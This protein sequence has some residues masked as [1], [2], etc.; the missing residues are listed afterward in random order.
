MNNHVTSVNFTQSASDSMAT[1]CTL[2]VGWARYGC[3]LS[4]WGANSYGQLGQGHAE[5]KLLPGEVTPVDISIQSISGGGGHTLVIDDE[6]N[7]FVCG[8]NNKGQL[9]LGHTRDVSTLTKVQLPEGSVVTKATGGWDFTLII[10]AAGE[11]FVMGSNTFGQLGSPGANQ[12]L[13]PVKVNVPNEE[14]VRDV[15][16][17]LRHV[18]MVTV[19]GNIYCW[20]AG[21]KGQCGILVDNKPPNRL[22]TPVLVRIPESQE[23]GLYEMTSKHR[24][25]L[26]GYFYT[27]SRHVSSVVTR[28]LPCGAMHHHDQTV[29]R[30]L[31]LMTD[32]DQ[33]FVLNDQIVTRYLSLI[34]DRN[35]MY[36]WGCNKYGQCLK[37]PSHCS[38]VTTPSP[39]PPRDWTLSNLSS[40]W[41]HLLARTDEGKLYSWGRGDYG[42]LGRS[43]DR[44]CDHV[45]TQIPNIPRVLDVSCGSE[46]NLAV[47]E[48]ASVFSWGWNEHGIC[49]TGD[50][51][52]VYKPQK[53]AALSK[54]R[55]QLL[56]C[57][58]GQSL[59]Y[60]SEIT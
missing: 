48:D 60:G 58:N 50:E 39:A 25:T 40:G 41:T 21:R 10:T 42:Q 5:D 16:A 28:R 49:G 46:H 17:G 14:K 15:A 1:D 19:S 51:E 8:S 52:N 24:I 37:D 56:G 34:T 26:M 11:L 44:S 47:T 32:R 6:G 27:Y 30:Y 43:C 53:V 45:P 23:K 59:V 22:T 9:G 18:V 33:V 7:L 12:V 55:I 54:L 2:A 3:Q 38:S 31:S 36:F 13:L 35:Q 29:T 20:G 4:S 57:G